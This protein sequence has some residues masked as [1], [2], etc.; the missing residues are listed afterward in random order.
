METKIP[1]KVL[2]ILPGSLRHCRSSWRSN[3]YR[4]NTGCVFNKS[5]GL[6]LDTIE[7][8]TSGSC[9][10]TG[11]KF[12]FKCSVDAV[13]VDLEQIGCALLSDQYETDIYWDTDEWKLQDHRRGF[14]TRFVDSRLT[15]ELKSLFMNSQGEFVVEEIQFC[16]SGRWNLQ[17]LSEVLSD[18]GV[19]SDLLEA[20]TITKRRVPIQYA[21]A[22]KGYIA[23]IDE[24]AGLPFFLQLEIVNGSD[25]TFTQL[26]SQFEMDLQLTPANESYL[27]M[28]LKCDGRLL[29]MEEFSRR[30]RRNR[31][32]KVRPREMPR[33]HNLLS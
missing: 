15:A 1:W 7:R 31:L 11:E 21:S 6:N 18:A 30:F 10:R 28:V 17:R 24:I 5:T 25:P 2:N 12:K 13:V 20:T 9:P 4:V 26:C 22:A 23:F 29:S 8:I 27:D 14:R 32:W 33:V 3:V 19:C 16:K